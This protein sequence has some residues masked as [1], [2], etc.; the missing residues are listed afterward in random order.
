[1]LALKQE[2][3]RGANPPPGTEMGDKG[4]EEGLSLLLALKI[5]PNEEGLSLFL[6]NNVNK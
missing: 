6:H 5:G 4:G 1:M 3:S 2:Q